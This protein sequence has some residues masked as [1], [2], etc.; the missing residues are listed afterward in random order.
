MTE[1]VT[2]SA[3]TR[4][5]AG[6]GSARAARRAGKVPGVI[7]GAKKDPVM[8]NVPFAAF[9]KELHRPG[10]F[11]KLFDVE[12]SGARHRVLPRDVAF[13]P[14]TDE[15]IHVDFLR[16]SESTTVH[17]MVPVQFQN[18]AASPGLKVGGVLNVVRHEIE[19]VC[20]ADR[21]PEHLV[22]DLTGTKI[23]DS[24][25][26]SAVSLPEGSRPAIADRDF[27]IATIAP[28][29]TDREAAVAA[30]DAAG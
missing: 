18:E 25:H 8:I 6:K 2:I 13:D 10:F 19:M 15:P 17:V 3:E 26:I 4:D 30:Q 5:R 11:T 22:V 14:V 23:G 16:V 12:V 29:T 7:Y 1:I 21:I 28:P 24:I 9:R 20:R 27:T